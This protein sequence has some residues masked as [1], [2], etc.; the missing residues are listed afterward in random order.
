[1]T[2]P[3]AVFDQSRAIH[4]KAMMRLD[5]LQ[6]LSDLEAAYGNQ[7]NI[8]MSNAPISDQSAQ[9]AGD[10]FDLFTK[11]RISQQFGNYNPGLYAGRTK[12]SRHWGVDI[13]TPQ[14]TPVYAPV[15]GKVEYGESP[16][17]GK[18]ARVLGDDGITYQ[19]SHLSKFGDGKTLGY[20]GNTGYSTAP[21]L[22]IMTKQGG[23]YINPMSLKSLKKST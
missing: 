10:P 5:G 18:Y 16:T 17:F 19:F 2:D 8:D 3:N 1:M 9:F 15:S 12:D 23:K 6:Q 14:G 21:H 11:Y 20:T 22:D 4:K 13:A 7:Q